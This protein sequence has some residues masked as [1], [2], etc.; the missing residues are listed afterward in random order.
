[1][2]RENIKNT[3]FSRALKKS[4][5]DVIIRKEDILMF[6]GYL[7]INVKFGVKNYFSGTL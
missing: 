4:L 5:N 1:M 2:L 7:K 6:L 3:Y